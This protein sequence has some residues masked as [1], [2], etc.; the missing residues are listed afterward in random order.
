M[1]AAPPLKA[2]VFDLDGLLLN[3]EEL[4]NDVGAEMLRRRGRQWTPELLDAMMGRPSAVALQ[5]M[6]DWHRLDATVDDLRE[7]SDAIFGHLLDTRL[8]PMPGAIELL[9]A[10]ECAGI[11]KAIGTSSR[12]AFVDNVLSRFDWEPRF[13]F[14]LTEEDVVRGKPHP[15]IYLT[16]ARRLGVD[17]A[18]MMVLEDSANGCR[19]AV[20]AGA[21]AVAVPG[22]PSRG[23]DFGGAALVAE[24][25]ADERIYG[26]LR[27]EAPST[28]SDS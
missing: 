27:I 24:S 6:I 14:V 11:P 3:T 17:G 22:G 12:R 8:A 21:F 1:I 18:S 16:A 2:V 10:L 23:H 13:G 19:A 4:Y 9:G 25:L 7:E 5:I 15:E 26:A 28:P 20:A